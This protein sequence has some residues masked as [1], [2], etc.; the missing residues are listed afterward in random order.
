[1][2]EQ[3]ERNPFDGE[4]ITERIEV[5]EDGNELDGND[6]DHVK[7]FDRTFDSV[8]EALEDYAKVREEFS[9]DRNVD[10][11]EK[12]ALKPMNEGYLTDEELTD[13]LEN[14]KGVDEE[15]FRN[16]YLCE[17]PWRD[18]DIGNEVNLYERLFLCLG[19][20]RAHRTV[21]RLEFL[22]RS[23]DDLVRI[24]GKELERDVGRILDALDATDEKLDELRGKA[25]FDS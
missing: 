11:D 13:L 5:D 2:S 9:N 7:I 15:N 4:R 25:R 19:A 23:S 22:K 20:R 17:P 3:N 1:M 14:V 6:E 18:S 24:A 10:R 12:T 8:K 16:E 21:N